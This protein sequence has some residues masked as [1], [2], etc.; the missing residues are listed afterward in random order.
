MKLKTFLIQVIVGLSII[1]AKAQIQIAVNPTQEIKEI[2]PYIYGRNN[3]LSDDPSNATKSSTWQLYKDAGLKFFRESGGNN[4]TKYNWKK[5]LS[6][7]PD[8]YNNV[9]AHDWDYAANSLQ[10]NMPEAKGMWAFQLLGYVAK[11]NAYNFNDWG[12]NGSQWWSGVTN[13]WCG[14]GGPTTGNGDPNLYLQPWPAD[15]TAAILTHW[16]DDLNFNREQ[17][18]YWNMDNEPECWNSTHDD[19]MPQAISAEDYIQRYVDVA[20]RV[21]ALYPDIKIVGPVFTNEWQWYNWQNNDA[22][23]DPSSG[24]KYCWAEYFIKR[25]AEIEAQ[26]GIRLLD[27]LDFHFYP[28][29]DETGTLQLYRVFY[30]TSYNFPG[31][32]GLYRVNGGWDTSIKQEYIFKRATDWLNQYMGP[33]NGVTMGMSEFGAINNDPNVVAVSYA[34]MLGTFAQNNV[35]IFAP[36]D[37]YVGQWEVLH[38]FTHYTG[39]IA[40][41]STSSQDNVVSA[42]SS[43]N[44]GRDMLSVVLVNRDATNNQSVNVSLGNV[45]FPN[46]TGV[47]C[48]QLS[49]LPSS[50]TFVSDTRNALNQSATTINNNSVAL[51]LPKLSVTVIQINL[52]VASS[53]CDVASIESPAGATISGQTITANV[54]NE[55]TS[56]VVSITTSPAASWKLYSDAACTNEIPNKTMQLSVGENTAYIQVTAEDG[57]TTKIYTIVITRAEALALS[58]LPTSL[59]FSFSG[60]Q[61]TFSVTSNTGWTVGSD[62]SWLTVSPASGSNDGLI[63]VTAAANTETTQRT[64][65]ITVSGTGVA[66]QVISVTQEAVVPIIPVLSVSS[67]SMNFAAS[68][69]QQT[70]SVTSNTDWTVG[71]DASWLTVSPAFGSNDGSITVT[72]AA[73]TETTQ[74]TATITVSGT[75]V[76]D[77]VVSVTQEAVEE[78]PSIVPDETQPVGDDGKGT[79]ELNFSIPSNATLTGSFEIQFPK[80]VTLDEQLTVL[81][82]ELSG[83]S[84][85]AFS[86]E[87]NNTWLIEIKSNTLKSSTAAEYQKIVDIAY[88]VN[89]N[90]SKGTYEATIMNLDFMLDNNTTIK[91]DLLTVPINVERSGTS[92]ENIDNDLFHAYFINNSLKIESSHSEL[93]TI[94]SAK[95]A[96]LYTTMKNAGSIE[97]PFTSTPGSIFFVKGSVS[98]TIKIVK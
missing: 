50:E 42:Y 63:T 93:I 92:I 97:I 65:T 35:E 41:G 2:S 16:F 59:N 39:T 96:I 54:A 45:S 17:F 71:S 52:N 9:Y 78:I 55:V 84:Y 23:T 11:T 13:N 6:S 8:W 25:I 74:R 43:V 81:S 21:R 76:A 90:V 57:V 28:S 70:F 7:H 79:I 87:G 98:G 32:N 83:N 48:Y 40:V 19:I 37:W 47:S 69:E 66:D 12:Y 10:A 68:G 44:D 4:S 51:T 15:S 64:A 62:A 89:E 85:L 26:T 95:G 80:G 27:V 73:N 31:A 61:Q 53:A 86:Y 72:A 58:V 29:S 5:K 67:A 46:G 14:G 1:S 36:W 18:Q 94:Y 34:S 24:K 33:D 56:Q 30:D 88:I 22:V 82:L 75:G 38:L 77:Q 60:E 3:N 20:T 49:N 91:E